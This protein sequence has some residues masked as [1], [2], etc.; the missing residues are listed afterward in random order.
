MGNRGEGPPALLSTCRRDG[1]LSKDTGS[2][3]DG[4]K[5]SLGLEEGGGD[6][7]AFHSAKTSG[8][9]VKQGDAWVAQSV[10]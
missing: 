2:L 7:L 3:E 1:E 8:R 5:G 9:N 6:E 10:R 4:H